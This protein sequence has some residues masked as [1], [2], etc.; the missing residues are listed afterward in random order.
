VNQRNPRIIHPDVH[1]ACSMTR[2]LILAT[3]NPEISG[4][5]LIHQP[6]LIY[7]TVIIRRPLT[8]ADLPQLRIRPTTMAIQPLF[9]TLDLPAE[10]R[11]SRSALPG[12]GSRITEASDW[13]LF[14]PTLVADFESRFL[15]LGHFKNADLAAA[16]VA[17]PNLFCANVR[18]LYTLSRMW[19]NREHAAHQI[20]QLLPEPSH[21]QPVRRVCPQGPFDQSGT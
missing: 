6:Q 17:Y 13:R 3:T 9:A 12:L 5:R 10:Q 2:R 18:E 16:S 8:A 7:E 21:H 19:P 4:M 14:Q 11:L 20:G 15:C 1:S